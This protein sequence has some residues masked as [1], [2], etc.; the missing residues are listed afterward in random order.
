MQG[1]SATA[2]TNFFFFISKKKKNLMNKALFSLDCESFVIRV[3]PR[4][5]PRSLSTME[6]QSLTRRKSTSYSNVLSDIDL[7]T[8]YFFYPSIHSFVD[9]NLVHW[10]K[11]ERRAFT[12]Y[13]ISLLESRFVYDIS[14]LDTLPYS[15][16]YALFPQ[17]NIK[18]ADIC[19]E[20]NKRWKQSGKKKV[21]NLGTQRIEIFK[22]HK[23]EV[24]KKGDEKKKK[25]RSIKKSQR[26]W[27][28]KSYWSIE[29]IQLQSSFVWCERGVDVK[30][31][32]QVVVV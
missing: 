32:E 18:V 20:K 27:V 16:D 7:D 26:L 4:F 9:Y 1:A 23:E 5:H 30:E 25:K 3:C 29:Q 22:Y 13:F 17:K 21:K 31:E 8:L 24:I 28:I 2:N 10:T 19:T 14:I 6:L 11:S 15:D 12:I